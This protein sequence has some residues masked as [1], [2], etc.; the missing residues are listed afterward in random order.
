MRDPNVEATL[1]LHLRKET[2]PVPE[3]LWYLVFRI[4]GD[5]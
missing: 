5:G 3:T 4:P 2:D 1:C